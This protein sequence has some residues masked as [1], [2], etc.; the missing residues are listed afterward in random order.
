M[1]LFWLV[2]FW[3]AISVIL[4]AYFGFPLLLY[5]TAN[6]LRKRVRKAP[7]LPKISLIIA[8]YNEAQGIAKKIENSLTLDYPA[9]K[10]EIII[11][12]DGSTDSTVEIA[13]KYLSSNV[14]VLSFPR[15]GKIFALR[16]S[17]QHASGE[18]LVFS[19]A[20]TEYHPQALKELAKNFA[21]PSVGGVCGNQLHKNTK[22]SDNASE[23][24]K[25]Y[26]QYDK[27]LKQAETLTG[28]I[29][30]A[31]GAI[32]A[33]RR[34]LFEMPT[35][36]AVTDD[37]A[38]STG[39]ITKGYRLVFDANALAYEDPMPNAEKEFSRKVRIM[40]RGLRGV[41]MRKSLLNP[42]KTGFYAVILFAHKVLRRLVPFFLILLLISSLMLLNYAPF[43]RYFAILQLVFYGLA[44]L[45]WS[46]R[47]TNI[48]KLKPLYIPFFF[49]LANAAAF[50][51]VLNIL[52]GKRIEQWTPGRN[53]P[54]V[55]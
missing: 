3:G 23:G 39:V 37:F 45:G 10:L 8:A 40:N 1:E 14:K 30:S 34:E 2:C 29:V 24:E 50:I 41:M 43:Y 33:I 20:N 38:I 46:I 27:W 54:S 6:L 26:W 53:N 28:S 12:S 5:I 55:S 17:L 47:N 9:D 16:D 25:L 31:D 15:R 48:A 49:C 32:Y 52:T 18:I 36:T 19:D 4:F 44:L 7:F 21:D 13:N 22:T 35:D 11:A 42:F 51:A